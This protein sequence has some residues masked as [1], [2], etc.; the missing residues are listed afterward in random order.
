MVAPATCAPSEALKKEARAPEQLL[1]IPKHVEVRIHHAYSNLILDC[2][3]G[4]AS[5]FCGLGNHKT[6]SSCSGTGNSDTQT[7][8]GMKNSFSFL[9]LTGCLN[10]GASYKCGA[11]NFKSGAVCTGTGASDT[12]TCTGMHK[13]NFLVFT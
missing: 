3:N 7:C 12:Q 2:A 9:K 5:Y 6:G 11:G 10:G 1:P 8:Q 13:T 4:G